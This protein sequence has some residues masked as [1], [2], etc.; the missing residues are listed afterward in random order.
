[1]SE[2][3]FGGDENGDYLAGQLLVAMPGMRDPRFHRTVIYMCAH[4]ADGPGFIL[5]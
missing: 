2:F 5:K 4:N 1:M 3:D